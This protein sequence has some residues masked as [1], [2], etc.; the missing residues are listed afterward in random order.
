M[1]VKK[2]LKL[3]HTFFDETEIEYLSINAYIIDKDKI[4]N[5]VNEQWNLKEKNRPFTSAYEINNEFILERKSI[6]G[7]IES[8]NAEVVY[9]L[10]IDDKYF[11]LKE[12]PFK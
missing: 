12:I 9:A 6:H 10:Y 4:T 11:E 7:G 2:L 1:K 8:W 5:F 3:V